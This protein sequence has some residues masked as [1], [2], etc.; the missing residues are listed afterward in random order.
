LRGKLHNNALIGHL[1][2]RIDCILIRCGQH[3]G[4]ALA[5]TDCARIYVLESF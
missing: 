4:P 3:G 5:I 1:Y 2:R